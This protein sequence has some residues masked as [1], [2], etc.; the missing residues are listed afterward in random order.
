[1]LLNEAEDLTPSTVEEVDVDGV[2]EDEEVEVEA[3]EEEVSE[4]VTRL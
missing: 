1:M 3:E 4:R 2:E